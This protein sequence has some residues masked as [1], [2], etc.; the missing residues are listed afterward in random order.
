MFLEEKKA[1]VAP[2]LL[3]VNYAHSESF[4]GRLST[5]R[6]TRRVLAPEE[7]LRAGPNPVQPLKIFVQ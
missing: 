4:V 2:V 6:A 1:S 7:F 5:L 3:G